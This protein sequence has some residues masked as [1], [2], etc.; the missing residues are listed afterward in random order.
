MTDKTDQIAAAAA[1][2]Q[3]QTEL[4]KL[5][6][7]YAALTWVDD[8]KSMFWGGSTQEY[9]IAYPIPEPKHLPG[10]L[11]ADGIVLRRERAWSQL[12]RSCDPEEKIF[13]QRLIDTMGEAIGMCQDRMLYEGNA[14]KSRRCGV[15]KRQIEELARWDA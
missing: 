8:V 9:E 6:A 5:E 3:P 10:I 13:L 11:T 12:A 15:L 7:E 1:V 14:V 4:E 2:A